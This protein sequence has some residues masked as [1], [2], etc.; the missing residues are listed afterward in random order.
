MSALRAL[1]LKVESDT[2]K[3]AIKHGWKVRKLMFVGVRG[4]PDRLFGKEGESVLIEFKRDGEVPGLQ[5]LRRHVELRDVFGFNV[6]W[7]DSY[8]EACAILGIPT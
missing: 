7:T 4:A 6:H 2:V 8:A 1:E 5:Q 3:Q